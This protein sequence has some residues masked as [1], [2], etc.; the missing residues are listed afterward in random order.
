MI[1]PVRS[2]RS[3]M[4]LSSEDAFFIYNFQFGNSPKINIPNDKHILH[5]FLY[6]R[7]IDR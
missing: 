3:K 5:A 7:Y 6:L 2:L 1:C 4:Q